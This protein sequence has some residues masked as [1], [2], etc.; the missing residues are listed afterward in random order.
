MHYTSLNNGDVFILDEGMTIHCW[1]GSQCS[2]TE[3]M[4]V[5][6]QIFLVYTIHFLVGM[7]N[8][9]LACVAGARGERE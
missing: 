3:R 1:N 2:R 6:K 8:R 5:I 4:K 9:T 7:S